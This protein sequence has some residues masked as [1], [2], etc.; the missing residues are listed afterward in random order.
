MKGVTFRRCGCRDP[1]TG[2]KYK[3]GQCPRLLSNK[4]ADRD[5]GSWW[6]RFDAPRGA[7]GRRR[8]PRLG[9]F[10][11]QKDAENAIAAE[12]TRLGAGGDI[13]DK[14]MLVRD[15]LQSWLEGKR[16]LKPTTFESTR[17]RSGCISSRHSATSAYATCANI[18]SARW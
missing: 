8:Q 18:T 5:H 3:E 15:Y 4:R 11:T 13:S 16:S 17:S 9:P 10:A 2:K 12:I 6:G 14:K 7:N 1:G